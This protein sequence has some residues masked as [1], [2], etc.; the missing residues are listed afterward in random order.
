MTDRAADV[1]RTSF[2]ALEV[3]GETE[4]FPLTVAVTLPGNLAVADD[5]VVYSTPFPGMTLVK[6]EAHA[7]T[8]PAGA[9]AILQVEIGTTDV[10]TITI[11]DGSKK[12]E[13]TTVGADAKDMAQGTDI[14]INVD[15]VG[16]GTPGADT[17]VL[18]T[19][20]VPATD[21]VAA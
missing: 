12:G 13:Q 2:A 17:D 14:N 6:A 10:A 11:P 8:A 16:S 15:Q 18:L 4:G 3:T 9:D 1:D 20:I 19:F 7:K 21:G 5:Q